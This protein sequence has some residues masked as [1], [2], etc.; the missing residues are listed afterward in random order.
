MATGRRRTK[1]S[2]DALGSVSDG[3]DTAWERYLQQQ[4]VDV[5]ADV[6]AEPIPPEMAELVGQLAKDWGNP[7]K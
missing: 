5:Y 3:S 1:S 7:S 2:A 6:L 4:L